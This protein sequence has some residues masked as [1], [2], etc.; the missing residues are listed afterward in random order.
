M[1]DTRQAPLFFDGG[2]ADDDAAI[3][4]GVDGPSIDRKADAEYVLRRVV[5]P[6]NHEDFPPR[7]QFR[8]DRRIGY[9]DREFGRILVPRRLQTFHTDLT[10]VPQLLTW[11]VPKSGAHLPAALIHD[12]LV[13]PPGEE[14]EYIGANPA[15]SRVDAD[16]IFRDA[17][18]DAG[19]GALRRWL[20]WSAVTIATLWNRQGTAGSRALRVYYQFMPVVLLASIAWLGYQATADVVGRS[21]S[22]LCTYELP[23]IVGDTFWEEVLSGGLFAMLIPVAMSVLWWRFWRAGAIAGIALAFLFHV[24]LGI[25]AVQ[26][27]NVFVETIASRGWGSIGYFGRAFVRRVDQI[28]TAVTVF[29]AIGVVCGVLR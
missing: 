5:V 8:L 12:G 24:T 14:P 22:W 21:G 20:V 2:D 25:A 28:G 18:R 19:T 15:I 11:L 1:K 26:A 13:Y 16:R 23:W 9:D 7:E 10:S 3:A 17:M 27:V 6:S 29:A 4:G